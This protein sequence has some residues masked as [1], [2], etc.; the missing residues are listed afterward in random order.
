V[1]LLP[2]SARALIAS[3][4]HGHLVTINPD[5]APQVSLVWVGVDGDELV[6]ASM[7]LR[8]KVRN[9]QRDPRVV[10]SFEDSETDDQRGL[11]RYLTV[12]GSARISEGGAPERLQEL[13]HT[14]LGP[15]V[16][17]PQ[18]ENLPG[19]YV[20]RIVLERWSGNGPWSEPVTR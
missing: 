15:G 19:G 8:Q 11:L 5:G 16:R 13:A 20:M 12:V 17:F 18:G 4:A 9:V 2:E 1:A 14:Y 10:L 7:A 6:V 3:G